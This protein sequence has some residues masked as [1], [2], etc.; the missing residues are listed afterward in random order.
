MPQTA[1][2]C[3]MVHQSLI[4]KGPHYQGSIHALNEA[5]PNL[6]L[7]APGGTDPVRDAA[8]TAGDHEGPVILLGGV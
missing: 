2:T 3:F 8:G 5:D 7:Q 6:L 1:L 4:M